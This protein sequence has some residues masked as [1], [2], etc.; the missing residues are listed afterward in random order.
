MK[1]KILT[2]LLALAMVLT[3]LPM[4]AL[5]TSADDCAGDADCQ[6][7]AA[8]GTTHYDTLVEAYA[9]LP[10]NV[11]ADAEP[12]VITLLRDC[13]GGGI[14][15]DSDKGMNYVVDFNGHTYTVGAPA[16]GSV[17]TVSQGLRVMQSSKAVFKNGTL[18]ADN[19]SLLA[20]V[21]H[22][23]GDV[24][25][26]DFTIDCTADSYAQIAVEA[27]CGTLNILGNSSILARNAKSIGLYAAFWHYGNYNGTTVNVDTTGKIT[28]I[29]KYEFDEDYTGSAA[30]TENKG[31]LNIQKGNFEIGQIVASFSGVT[32]PDLKVAKIN[33]SGGTFDCID[34]LKY[35]TNG[36]NVTVKLSSD[37]S[38][39]GRITIPSGADVVLDLNGKTFTGTTRGLLD[40]VGSLLDV[41]A[42][43][44]TVQD[45]SA[46]QSGKLVADEY[47]ISAANNGK[48]IVNSGTIESNYAALSG[49]NTNGDMNFEVNGGTLTSKLSEAIYMPG[50]VNL[51]VTGGEINGGISTRMG[52]IT[53][54]G[55]TINGM[56]SGCDSISDYYDYSGSAWIGDAIYVLAGTYNSENTE[57]GNT[58]NIT[59][60][61]GTINGSSQH[62]IAVYE[63]GTGEAQNVNVTING[64]MFSGAKGA[65]A[66]VSDGFEHSSTC[67]ASRHQTA[68]PE[69]VNTTVTI[70]A[71]YFT[72]EPDAAYLAPGKAVYLSNL[73]GY[74]YIVAA[75]EPATPVTPS[76]PAREP[77]Q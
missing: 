19:Y 34:A 9:N 48:I 17:G 38:T 51:L 76:E 39:N 54:T 63:I 77:V 23:Y 1:R 56:A 8:I 22:T 47:G 58:A 29:L 28:G 61:G 73:A 33:I 66:V 50:Q 70:Y 60:S 24:T 67:N 42:A 57:Y 35:L 55:G 31:I 15:S 14:G 41:N 69:R 10:R 7:Q 26:Q 64:G 49:N 75:V 16:V 32:N 11:K 59:I 5:A 45:S 74:N 4:T 68:N 37:V 65:V 21:V 40:G 72:S 25:L 43:T 20:Q 52:Q 71:G 12:T 3:M 53:V 2:L 13:A 27:D 44:L 30:A 18:K 46:G 6:H 62:G 36:A